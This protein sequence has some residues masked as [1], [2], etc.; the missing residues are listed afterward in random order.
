NTAADGSGTGFA[1]RA[2]YG[3]SS[4]VTLFAQWKRV[5]YTVTFDANGGAGS[6]AA[7]VGYEPTSLTANVFARAGYRFAGWNTAANGSG[8]SYADRAQ[9]PFSS[10]GT[11]YA[12]WSAEHTV[13]FDANGGIG[14]MSGQVEAFPAPLSANV[15][16]REG[17]E[18]TGWNTAADG[19]GTAYP[20]GEVYSFSSSVTLFAQWAQVV[21]TVAFDG[22]GGVGTMDDQ[23]AAGPAELRGNSF[24]RDGYRFAGWNTAADGSGTSY[25]DRAQFP[26]SSSGTL[27]AQWSAEHTVTFDANGGVG[28]MSGQVEAFPAPLSANVFTREGYEF[29][30]WNTA[31]DGTGTAYPDGEVYSF[32]SSVTLFAQ[33]AQVVYTVAFDGNGGVGTMDDQ[34]AAGPAELRGNSFTRDGY[35]F[36]GWNTAADGSGT[37]YADRAQFP[38]SSSGT[39]YAQWSAEHT[40]TFDAN[41]GIGSMDPQ[42]DI[43]PGA[44]EANQ[45]TR[46][47]Y[48]FTGWNTAANGSGA[49]YADRAQFP[50]SFSATLF[51]QWKRVEYTVT[52]E[53]NGGGGSMM[54]Q[55][56][57]EP[58]PLTANAFDRS[59]FAFAGWNTAADGSGAGYADRARFH[60]SAS[61]TLHAQWAAEHTVTF[62]SNGGAG[63]M[64]P[65]VSAFPAPLSSSEFSREGYVFAGWNTAADGSGISYPEAAQFPFSSSVTLY[66]QWS[67]EHTVTFDPNGGTGI[68]SPQ[69]GST[70]GQLNG[71]AFTRDGYTFTGWNTKADGTG[72]AYEAG[73]VYSFGDDVTLF[74]QWKAN[75]ILPVLP[76]TG[77]FVMAS[78]LA[79]GFGLVSIIGGVTLRRRRR[80]EP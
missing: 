10:S 37:S 78:L 53:A 30:G 75:G 34:V 27:Y 19:T 49:A 18:F 68:M 1:D 25:A 5:E 22:N 32:S 71:N 44:L 62:D 28:S 79:F 24:T 21:Y 77:G 52:F 9:F 50:F 73:A 51:A 67:A 15:F 63:D 7:Q 42:A 48:T 43:E 39:L 31:A 40:V 74:A 11:L 66:A 13:T 58:T 72:A 3:F 70:P 6:M 61:L 65:Q 80:Q 12:Q 60:F 23:V 33:W 76:A 69:T 35:R 41:G 54:T 8:T 2:E 55:S 20:D 64:E 56:G 16:T 38:F 45:F 29:T 46:G 57:F 14:S 47:G 26:F 17:Y 59:G 4:S 36:A